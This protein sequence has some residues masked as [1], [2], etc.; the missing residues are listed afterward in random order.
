MKP[1]IRSPKSEPH[2][3]GTSTFTR[4]S[5]FARLPDGQGVRGSGFQQR[6][7]SAFTLL[8]MVVSFGIFAT[9][10]VIATGAVVSIS[11]AQIKA[12]NIQSIQDNLRFA[13]ESMTKE[14]RTGRALIPFG[15][16]A[17]AYGGVSF[18]R[19]D[20]SP[21]GYCLDG[22]ALKK[23]S[24]GGQD[25]GAAAA[26]TSDDIIVDQLVFYVIG[27]AAGPTDGQPRITV[28]LRAHS[29]NPKLQTAFQLQ[30]T[31]V[32]RELDSQL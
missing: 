22:A 9:V 18:I 6:E 17:P 3:K 25:C 7:R 12:A 13:V 28:S 24:G 4:I 20:G 21:V 23:I 31:V 27:H 15:G 19:S 26:M 32:Q 16:T 5:R 1:E 10:I 11:Q 29:R 30:T 2:L 8:E 14:M